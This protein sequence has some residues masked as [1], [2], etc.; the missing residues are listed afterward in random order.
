MS[1]EARGVV[2]IGET[3]DRNRSDEVR[4]AAHFTWNTM[5][6]NVNAPPTVSITLTWQV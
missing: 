5:R 2:R 6:G 4:A 3:D 1:A